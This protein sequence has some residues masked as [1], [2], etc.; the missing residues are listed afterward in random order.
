MEE[1]KNVSQLPCRQGVLCCVFL[2]VGE[3]LDRWGNFKLS[4]MR[5]LVFWQAAQT[6]TA[7]LFR[8]NS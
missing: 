8:W 7:F 1:G 3:I 2:F 5:F 6:S 4:V